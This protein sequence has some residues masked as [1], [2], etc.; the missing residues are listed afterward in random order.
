MREKCPNGAVFFWS[1]FSRIWTEDGD[2]LRKISKFS[3]NAG[4]YRLEKSPYLDIFHVVIKY[5][6]L[7]LI[8]K[9]QNMILGSNVNELLSL[10]LY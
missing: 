6:I 9:V 3:P 4:K 1:V 10:L 5:I 8:V 2:L 7:C